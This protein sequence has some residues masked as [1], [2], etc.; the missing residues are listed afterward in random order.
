MPCMSSPSERVKGTKVFKTTPSRGEATRDRRRRPIPHSRILAFT[1]RLDPEGVGGRRAPRRPPREDDDIHGRR[2]VRLSPGAKPAST[3]P[4]SRTEATETAA[5]SA[6]TPLA[7]APPARQQRHRR[8]RAPTATK[9]RTESATS[10][11]AI[12]RT[13]RPRSRRPN[14]HELRSAQEPRCS[15]AATS[16]FPGPPHCHL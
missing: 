5:S 15:R 8:T 10:T 14:D 1:R 6:R 2:A 12:T 9:P 13:A 16:T 7:H 4:R 11:A 3:P